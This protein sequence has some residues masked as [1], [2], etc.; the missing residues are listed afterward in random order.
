MDISLHCNKNNTVKG[1]RRSENNPEQ[2]FE[3]A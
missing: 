1:T 2:K 3:L